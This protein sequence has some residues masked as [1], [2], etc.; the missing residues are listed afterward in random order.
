MKNLIIKTVFAI[1]FLGFFLG[2]HAI[3]SMCDW[4]SILFTLVNLIVFELIVIANNGF[5]TEEEN[6]KMS[7]YELIDYFDV[8]GD[9]IYG[10]EVNNQ[11]VVFNDLYISDEAN[12][13]DI[14]EYLIDIK[15]LD[16]DSKDKILVDFD[17][18]FI[19]LLRKKDFFPICG[20][21]KVFEN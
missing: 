7:R 17:V 1:S 21:R 2:V 16:K 15:Y 5:Q 14:I 18:D 13:K 8:L 12:A 19:E 3:E 20:L 10:W 9:E 4:K 6:K 11:T